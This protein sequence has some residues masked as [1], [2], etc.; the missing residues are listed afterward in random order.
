MKAPFKV[1]DRVRSMQYS[2]M[3]T[4]KW[5]KLEL[6]GVMVNRPSNASKTKWSYVQKIEK[7]G[8]TVAV[9]WDSSSQG[10]YYPYTPNDLQNAKALELMVQEP[11]MTSD[12]IG[13]I[14]DLFKA[15]K[16]FMTID[17][18]ESLVNKMKGHL[19][20]SSPLTTKWGIAALKKLNSYNT[21]RSAS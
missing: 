19:D 13:F 2:I 1:G 6:N 17:E 21:E 15:N 7:G 16:E 8:Y 5:V 12:Q 9:N 3:G 4:V 10:I 18:Q 20:G 14:R 11:A